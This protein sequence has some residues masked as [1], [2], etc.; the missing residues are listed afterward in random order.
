[1][2]QFVVAANAPTGGWS[3]PAC[4]ACCGGEERERLPLHLDTQRGE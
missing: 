1:M 4:C 3:F 2:T